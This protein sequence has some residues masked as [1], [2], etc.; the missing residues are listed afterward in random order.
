MSKKRKK[1]TVYLEVSPEAHRIG[2]ELG[3]LCLT[4]WKS[5]KLL[6]L[7]CKMMW[8]AIDKYETYKHHALTVGEWSILCEDMAQVMSA[9]FTIREKL[10]ADETPRPEMKTSA[11][12]VIKKESE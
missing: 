5:F 3:H 6:A 1:T 2:Q 7:R 4:R 12:N 11:E 9:L 8:D 10:I